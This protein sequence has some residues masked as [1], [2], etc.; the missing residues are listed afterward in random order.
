MAWGTRAVPD[1]VRY[2]NQNVLDFGEKNLWDY[3]SVLLAE[4][5]QIVADEMGLLVNTTTERF[6]GYGGGTGVQFV[7]ANEFGRADASKPTYGGKVGLPLWMNQATVQWTRKYLQNATVDEVMATF[8]DVRLNDSLMIQSDIK[9]ALFNSSNRTVKDKLIDGADVEVKA[10]A[11]ADSFSYPA[12]PF[13]GAVDGSTHTHYLARVST[14]AASDINAVVDTV[15]EHDRQGRIRLLL[16]TGNV[17]AVRAFNGTGEFLG[18]SP[19]EIQNG[20]NVTIGAGTLDTGQQDD[21]RIGYW[22]SNAYE[23]WTKPWVPLNY[24]A[25]VRV[26]GPRKPLVWRER[27]VG[28]SALTLAVENEQFPLRADTWDREYGLAV[29]DRLAAAVLYIGGTSYVVPS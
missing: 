2:G 4:H 18:I 16:N 14:L 19:V 9:D 10:L 28:S 24:M 23:V 8:T 3:I 11:N 22:G 26:G 21:R 17:A 6:L 12:N 29:H 20:A 15:A 25:A 13:G 27:R 7:R 1:L 5:N